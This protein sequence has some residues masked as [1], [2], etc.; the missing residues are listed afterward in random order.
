MR[1]IGK[2]IGIYCIG[3]VLETEHAWSMF[4]TAEHAPAGA[5]QHQKVPVKLNKVKTKLQYLV[6]YNIQINKNLKL[7]FR[8]LK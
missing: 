7:R 3:N 2:C 6:L 5:T 1:C 8:P 4:C